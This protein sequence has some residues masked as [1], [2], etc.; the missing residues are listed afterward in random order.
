MP[1]EVKT[2]DT[3]AADVTNVQTQIEIENNLAMEN[4]AK[5]SADIF[6]KFI[7][8]SELPF[9]AIELVPSYLSNLIKMLKGKSVK[10]EIVNKATD[11]FFTTPVK[12]LELLT[13]NNEEEN[14]EKAEE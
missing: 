7:S 11:D 13:L 14:A 5:L 10:W 9:M 6:D 4:A 3:A 8:D 1:D 2:D 12:D